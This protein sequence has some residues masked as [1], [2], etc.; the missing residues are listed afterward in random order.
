MDR[1]ARPLAL[2]FHVSES[3]AHANRS[4]AKQDTHEPEK[5]AARPK[6][7]GYGLLVAVTTVGQVDEFVISRAS[8][9]H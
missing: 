1:E 4:R 6:A 2:P 7:F 5:R 8:A 3:T 9:P